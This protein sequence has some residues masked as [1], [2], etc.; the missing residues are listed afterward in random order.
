MTQSE[1]A[2]QLQRYGPQREGL[3]RAT[4]EEARQYCAQLARTHYENFTVGSCLL[5]K[6]LKQHFFNVYAYCRWADDLADEIQRP[7]RAEELLN[8]WQIQLSDCYRGLSWHPVFVA[9]QETIDEFDIP[10]D[11]FRNLLIAFRRD[12]QQ[13]HYSTFSELLEYCRHSANPVGHLVLF[14]GH[15]Y[16]SDNV[17]L[18]DHICTGLQL[19][20]FWQD[21]C[22]DFRRGRI[23]LPRETIAQYNC[24]EA[25]FQMGRATEG[26]RQ[27]LEHEVARAEQMLERGLP[28]V[29]RV[30]RSIRLEVDIFVHAGLAVLN[31]I[32]QCDFDVWS[33]RPTIGRMTK[34]RLLSGAIRRRWLGRVMR[35]AR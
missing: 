2:S 24:N 6:P 3:D 10:I 19:A 1:F 31:A 25:E 17:E 29:E 9:L 30:D 34:A 23:Y 7:E 15:S 16:N 13:K 21:V 35:G 20:N 27:A 8:W 33:E 18:S 14:L 12:Q 28:L 11:P 4:P 5:R 26:F 22:R 32:R